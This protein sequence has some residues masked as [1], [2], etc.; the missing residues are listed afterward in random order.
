[1]S[2]AITLHINGAARTIVVENDALLLDVLRE[3]AHCMSVRE[4]CGVGACGAC[5]AVVN[6]SPISTC[7]ALAVRYDGAHIITTEGLGADDPVVAAFIQAGAL[8]CGYCT[9]GIVLMVRDLLASNPTPVQE[10]I[11]EHLA[12]NICRCGAYPDIIRA[13]QTVVAAGAAPS[14]RVATVEKESQQ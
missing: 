5:T 4:G 13:V 8:Q 1:M 9:P 10:D 12:G 11:E 2:K 3:Q 14:V 7:L 6:G